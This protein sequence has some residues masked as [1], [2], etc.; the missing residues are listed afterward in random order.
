M[1]NK[2]YIFAILGIIIITTMS[3]INSNK[4]HVIGKVTW[5]QWVEFSGWKIDVN[6]KGGDSYD[7]DKNIVKEL[8]EIL[9]HDKSYS[10]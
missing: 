3:I 9:A 10:F 6:L 2:Y 5:E 4:A 8:N 1:Q 7:F